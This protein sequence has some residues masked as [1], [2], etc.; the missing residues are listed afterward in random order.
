MASARKG[1]V[2]CISDDDDGHPTMTE[3]NAS[4]HL[5]VCHMVGALRYGGA[6][7]QLVNL[8]NAMPEA[9]RTVL[10]IGAP[11]DEGLEQELDP[12]VQLLHLHVRLRR[13]PIDLL[14]LAWRLR[15]LRVDVLQTHMFWANVFGVIAAR[16]AGTPVIITTEHGDDRWWK[17]ALHRWIERNVITPLAHRRVCVSEHILQVRA[18]VEGVPRAKLL[19]IPNGTV[20]NE[21]VTDDPFKGDRT[22]VIGSVGRFVP[23]KD[24]PGLISA[25]ARLRD[26][27]L[28]FQCYLVGDGPERGNIMEAIRH[29]GLEQWCRLPGYQSN[30]AHWLNKFDVFV[31]GSIHEGQPMALLEAM[32]CGRAIVATRVGGIPM[33][34]TEGEEAL[35]VEAQNPEALAA[36]IRRLAEAPALRRRL[37]AAARER[38]IRDFS[39]RVTAERYLDLYTRHWDGPWRLSRAE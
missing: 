35:L 22:L 24:F 25:L 29:H 33:T 26:E 31:L 2:G 16:L 7:R 8:L 28:Q 23:E 32:A 11:V 20:V 12:Q 1:M 37:G 6:E 13:F 39:S 38:V 9:Q 36:A 30:I 4:G 21:Q 15:R 5:H 18:H 14:R 3:S 27:G 10:M 19:H 34:V 17:G